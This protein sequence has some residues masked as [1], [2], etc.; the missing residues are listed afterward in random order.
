MLGGNY[1]NEQLSEAFRK[2]LK[3]RFEGDQHE[4]NYDNDDEFIEV[5]HSFPFA[6]TDG[7]NELDAITNLAPL[8]ANCQRMIHHGM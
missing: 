8:C 1:T 2:Y 5:H 7:I 4:V 6:H 3:E